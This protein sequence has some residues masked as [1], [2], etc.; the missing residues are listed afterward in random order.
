MK[1]FILAGG[2]ATRLW[3]LTEKRAKPLLPLAGKP[4][5]TH[6]IENIPAEIPVIVSTNAV[7]GEQFQAWRNEV[8]RPNLEIVI[9]DTTHDDH[10]LGAVGAFAKWLGGARIND[11]VL[12]LTGDNYIGFSL[13]QFLRAHE[14]PAATLAAFDM[15]D[16][17]TAA[18]FGTV[19]VDPEHPRCVIGF[20]EKP[21][22]PKTSLVS[23]GFSIL[24]R[25]ALPIIV[26]FAKSYRDNVGGIFEELLRRGHPVTVHT[27]TEPWID[28][29][30]FPSYLEAH[31]LLVAG[32]TIVHPTASVEGTTCSESVVIGA[33]STV[34]TSDLRDSIIFNNCLIEDCVLRDCV[35]DEH[36]VLRGVDLT[37][38]M[39][40]A[41]THLQYTA[42]HAP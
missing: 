42:A 12:L 39:L 10:K 36:C 30:S 11:D 8:G 34:C 20:E 4:I 5:L 7:F 13:E 9:E 14:P 38:K 40:R 17:S 33:G 6:L 23:T 16:R 24:P 2:F 26:A 29:G 41:G 37:G 21:K 28:I 22:L 31:R 32:Q 1:A 15:G 18:A 19:L 25:T 3:P 35:I 27:F